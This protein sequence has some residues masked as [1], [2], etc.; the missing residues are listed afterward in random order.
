[1]LLSFIISITLLSWLLKILWKRYFTLKKLNEIKKKYNWQNK[2]KN[3]KD[4][5]Y[6]LKSLTLI[7]QPSL[8]RKQKYKRILSNNN[9]SLI[10]VN[11]ILIKFLYFMLN[12]QRIVTSAISP[13]ENLESF[14]WNVTKYLW[15]DRKKYLIIS[16]H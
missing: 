8:R 15:L 14:V 2:Y 5:I 12:I 4:Y 6:N 9:W 16:A 1:M 13:E 7:L 10:W 3:M 11:M